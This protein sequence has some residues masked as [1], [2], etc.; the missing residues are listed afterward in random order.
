MGRGGC[1]GGVKGRG[2]VVLA[3]VSS[4]AVPSALRGQQADVLRLRLADAVTL[5]AAQSA[6]V[7][8][9]GLRSRQAEAR[10]SNERADLLP[11]INAS[12][13]GSTH[14]MNT[15]TF[16]IDFPSVPGQPA[17][18]DPKGEIVGPINLLSGGAHLS[19][20]VFDWST[21]QSIRGASMAVDA[22]RVAEALARERAA[23]GAA[24]AYVQGM[25]AA[26]RLAA[27]EADVRLAEDLVQVAEATLAAG[28][29]VALDVT[30]ARAQL[31]GMQAQALAARNASDHAVLTL[32][33]A[34]NLP[35]DRAVELVDTLAIAA[36]PA[37]PAPDS[38]VA[39]A[40]GQRS[41]VQVLDE[42]V[43][44][45]EQRLSAV[46]A[47]RLPRL[48]LEGSDAVI[49]RWSG[50]KLN[51]YE[52]ALQVSVPVFDGM[53][54]KAR[55]EEQRA[56]IEELGVQRRQFREQVSFEVRSAILDM[57]SAGQ[58]LEASRARMDLA[59]QEYEQ[60][61]DRFSAGVAGSADVTTASLRLSE[62][63]TAFVDAQA[64]V[65]MARVALAAASGTAQELR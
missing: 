4:V 54:R 61:R 46:K 51:T 34:L 48:S 8:A 24:A 58:Q 2:V 41:D 53:R 30:R 3:L 6:A 22:G 37:A 14:T 7:E 57:G 36:A 29:G 31:A 39:R 62:A 32:L 50:Y 9:A 19:Q 15:G 13:L 11:Q 26:S 42:Q 55:M 52:L 59:Q 38:A 63:R 12:G 35:L 16:G 18:F 17:L 40:L 1:G 65:A 47:E 25:R 56:A 64:G 23:A 43:R 45:A 60:A 28:T 20:T 5:A 49:G 10:L 27:V 33:R 44:V 21:V